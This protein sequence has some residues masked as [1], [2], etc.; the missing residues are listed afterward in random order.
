MTPTVAKA[1][2]AVLALLQALASVSST[3]KSPSPVG[4]YTR[5]LDTLIAA[6]R[7]E[8]RARCVGIV[9]GMPN[10]KSASMFGS[11]EGRVE[12][13][14]AITRADVLTALTGGP[15]E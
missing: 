9:E 14:D 1:R 3:W 12:H 4:D 5:R 13:L 7:A 10:H 11:F 6:V 2:E 15:H 8:E